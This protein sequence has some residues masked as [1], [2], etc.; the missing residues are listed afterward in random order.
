MRREAVIA[1][2][3]RQERDALARELANDQR[4]ARPS[5]GRLN[6]HLVGNVKE[7]IE[8]GTADNAD[9]CQVAHAANVPARAPQVAVDAA[10][11][12]DF[13]SPD[14]EPDPELLDFPESLD[15][16]DSL[17]LPESPDFP[18][19]PDELDDLPESEPTDE[20][21]DEDPLAAPSLPAG[22]VLDPFRLS[23]R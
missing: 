9:L 8:P 12:E 10:T 23:V 17:D 5:E 20:L 19:S 3:P 2:M 18:E 6:R 4:I 21:S 22:T 7:L 1:A 16:P 13:L 14:P 15:F 11:D